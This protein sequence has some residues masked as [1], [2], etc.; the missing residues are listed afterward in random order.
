[1]GRREKETDSEG[2]Y[3]I[4]QRMHR[5]LREWRE[6]RRVCVC[7]G[8]RERGREI[9]KLHFSISQGAKLTQKTLSL[10][11]EKYSNSICYENVFCVN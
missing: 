5:G 8:E 4:E 2:M 7:E 6:G 9:L 3:D 1:M 10:C 11:S